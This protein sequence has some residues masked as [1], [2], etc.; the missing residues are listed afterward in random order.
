M[1]SAEANR[2]SSAMSGVKL[3]NL[4]YKSCFLMYKYEHNERDDGDL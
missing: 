2:K 3:Q 4:M 1:V